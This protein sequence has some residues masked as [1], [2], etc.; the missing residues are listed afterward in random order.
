MGGSE[1]GEDGDEEEVETDLPKDAKLVKSILRSMGVKQHEPR[2]VHQF[3]D[4]WY[5]YVVEVLGDAQLYSEHAGKPSIDSDDLKLAIQAR[6]SGGLSF[7]QPPP[8][9]VFYT[10]SGFFSCFFSVFVLTE[11]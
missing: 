1:E 3:L 11:R 2:V 10:S 5:R 4:F 9:E 6:I 7:S 8:R